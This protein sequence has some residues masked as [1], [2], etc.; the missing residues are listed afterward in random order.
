MRTAAATIV[1]TIAAGVVGFVAADHT[2]PDSCELRSVS[3]GFLPSGATDVDT[4]MA[5]GPQITAGPPR[6]STSWDTGPGLDV[7][8]TR[9]LAGG[10]EVKTDQIF[11]A[12]RSSTIVRGPFSATISVGQNGD[13][14][15]DVQRDSDF[16]NV[17]RRGGAVVG[18]ATGLAALMLRRRR[19]RP[20]TPMVPTPSP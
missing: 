9:A 13:G 20:P 4:R 5:V 11:Q 18:G 8:L 7:I 12:S 10:W 17:R 3:V 15:A 2:L 16:V 1:V 6:A 14:F 19:Q